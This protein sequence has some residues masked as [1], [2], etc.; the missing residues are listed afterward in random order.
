MEQE[1][2]IYLAFEQISVSNDIKENFK[3]QADTRLQNILTKHKKIVRLSFHKAIGIDNVYLVMVVGITDSVLIELANN[4]NFPRG[5]PVIWVPSQKMQYFGFYPKFSNDDRQTADSLTEFDDII[6]INF[7]KKWSG[8]LGQLI[9]FEYNNVLYWTVTSKNSA[10]NVSPFIL[11]AKRLFEPCL[12]TALLKTMVK[13][14]LHICAEI[15]SKNDQ[16]HGAKVLVETPVTTAIGSGCMYDLTNRTNTITN[17]KCFVEFFDNSQ[18]VKF[19]VE[20]GLPCD[21]AITISTNAKNFMTELSRL[22]DF[23]TDTK[24]NGLIYSGEYSFGIQPGTI[25]HADVLG[26]CLEGLVIK[27]IHSNGT[28]TIK[29]YKFAPYTIRTM[30]LREEFNNFV[31]IPSLMDKAKRFVNAWCVSEVGKLHWYKIALHAFLY[32]PFFKS[33]DPHIGD[34]IHIAEWA[35]QIP[36]DHDVE[37]IFLETI[38]TK[39]T[40]TVI[41]SLGPIGSGKTTIANCLCQK[42]DDLVPIDGDILGLD[43][44]TVTKLGKER[45]D[46]TKWKIIEALMLGKIPVISTGGGAL[47]TIGKQQKFDLKNQIYNT[48]GIIVKVIV[49]IAGNFKSIIP[50]DR[51]SE[52]YN[53]TKIY[54][55]TTMVKDAVIRRV[56]IGEWKIDPKFTSNTKV[57][58]E[59]ALE[60]FANTIV[61]YSSGNA[62]F[63]SIISSN[64]DEIFGFPVL[65][66]KNYGLQ[67]TLDYNEIIS[68]VVFTK[69]QPFG[70]FNQI[71]ILVLVEG[72]IG[73]ITY[74]YSKDIK[75]S[76]EEFINLFNIY[77]KTNII[78]ELFELKSTNGKDKIV[79]CIPFE[80]IHSDASTHITINSGNHLPKEMGLIAKAYRSGANTIS[81][82]NKDNTMVEYIINTAPKTKCNIRIVSSFGI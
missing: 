78:G 23:M 30:L 8:F 53:P 70:K 81:I 3:Q 41:I 31:L 7:F 28:Q 36:F 60:N 76:I 61:K 64:V 6:G 50:L 68:K 4:Y 63:A 45:N 17:N 38:A 65:T 47:F 71:R 66:E 62:K 27:L 35:E 44:E 49:C 75:F 34:H 5:F 69:P 58:Q 26:N 20:Y 67:N 77:G 48:L 39:T 16:T 15:I 73:H 54:E 10:S 29:K 2:P 79:I 42:N 33:P 72:V 32:Y 11:D 25:C 40:G 18:L 52:P 22:R 21:S 55:D 9:A 37:K 12:T 1:L 46:Y 43:K 74:K 19:C 59:K 57:S 24:L 82:P 80:S 51:T 13:N 56:S 14:N